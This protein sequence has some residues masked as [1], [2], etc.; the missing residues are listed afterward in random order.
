MHKVVW[1]HYHNTPPCCRYTQREQI[2]QS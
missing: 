1:S 2:P